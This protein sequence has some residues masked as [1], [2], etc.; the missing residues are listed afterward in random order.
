MLRQVEIQK[1]SI[2]KISFQIIQNYFFLLKHYSD[3]GYRVIVLSP[4]PSAFKLEDDPSYPRYGS[5]QDRNIATKIFNDILKKQA[6]IYAIDY[7]D[8]FTKYVDTY[9]FTKRK[10]LWD[11]IHPSTDVVKDIVLQLNLIFNSELTFSSRWIFREYLRKI[12]SIFL[13]KL[14]LKRLI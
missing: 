3:L 14:Y 8:I 7:L 4:P 10:Y 2:H 12:K 11:G 9:N 6:L 13:N 1:G 5:E